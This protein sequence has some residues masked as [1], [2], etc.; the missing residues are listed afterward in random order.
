MSKRRKPISQSEAIRLKK[1]RAEVFSSQP[2]EHFSTI[3]L[4]NAEA[5]SAIKMAR[6]LGA[7]IIVTTDVHDQVDIRVLKP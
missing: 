2:G 7:A 3:R 5:L 6:T 1:F 4:L